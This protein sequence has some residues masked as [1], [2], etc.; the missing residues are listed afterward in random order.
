MRRRH[1]EEK[2]EAEKKRKKNI[3]NF[4]KKMRM[5]KSLMKTN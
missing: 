5:E 4:N 2:K 3:I 1:A